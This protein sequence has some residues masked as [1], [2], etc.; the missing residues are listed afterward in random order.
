METQRCDPKGEGYVRLGQVQ[1]VDFNNDLMKWKL[2]KWQVDEIAN[3]FNK[4]WWN[5]KLIK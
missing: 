2:M 4:S 5:C 3:L 1:W